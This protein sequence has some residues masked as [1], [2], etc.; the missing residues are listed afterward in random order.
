MLHVSR[1]SRVWAVIAAALAALVVAACGSDSTSSSP[2]SG[3]SSSSSSSGS[4]GSTGGDTPA[5]K[6]A[7]ALVAK[8][9]ADQPAV[10][11]SPLPAKP[12]AGKS[13][14]V[15]TCGFPSCQATT[16]GVQAGG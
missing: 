5:I 9:S 4:S 1:N 7:K 10:A 6:A 14:A 15:L 8:Y 3:S 16:A 13:V 2:S 12:P 11:P